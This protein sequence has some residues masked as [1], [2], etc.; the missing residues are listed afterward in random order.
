MQDRQLQVQIDKWASPEEVQAVEEAFRRAGLEANVRAGQT[1]VC[2]LSSW[3]RFTSR[4]LGVVLALRE[5]SMAVGSFAFNFHEGGRSEYLALFVFS[6]FGTCVHVPRQEDH[7]I[8][9]SLHSR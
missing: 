6:A 1:R 3:Q 7:G 5:V 9:F 2:P 8:D 4:G